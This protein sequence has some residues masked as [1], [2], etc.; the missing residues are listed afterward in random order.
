MLSNNQPSTE[1]IN[2]V[3]DIPIYHDAIRKQYFPILEKAEIAK[4]FP[5]NWMTPLLSQ[6]LESGQA[7]MVLSTGTH[8]ARMQIIRPPFFLLHS[9]YQLWR[10]HPD[11]HHTW[12]EGCQRVSLTTV[13]A[14]EH[15]I[16]VNAKKNPKYADRDSRRLDTRTLYINKSLEPANWDYPSLRQMLDDLKYAQQLHPAGLYHL[17]CSSYHLVHFLLG[18]EK[19]GLIDELP[20]PSSIIHAYEYTP[21]NVRQFLINRFNCPVI[22]LFGST[23]LGYLYYND[24]NGHYTP[25]LDKMKIELIPFNPESTVYSLIVSS[26]RNPYMPLIRYR[27]GDCVQTSDGTADPEK[28]IRFCGREKE[29]LTTPQGIMSQ[30]EMDDLVASASGEIFIYQLQKGPTDTLNF[31]YTTFDGHPLSAEAVDNLSSLIIDK[32]HLP[33]TLAHTRYIPIGKSGKYAWLTQT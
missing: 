15:V 22:D 2:E 8:H 17:D 10:H 25:Y 13:L 18:L 3:K 24:Q 23:E 7:E 16:R 33:V 21:A 12:D 30:A 20:L 26:T 31:L 4:N 9:Y 28:V 29:M 27:S 5:D 19:H 1:M 14:T 32:T 11:I 6:A